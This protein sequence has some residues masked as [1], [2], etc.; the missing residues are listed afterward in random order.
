VNFDLKNDICTIFFETFSSLY[1][2]NNNGEN[3]NK[4]QL[5]NKRIRK[6]DVSKVVVQI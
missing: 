5:K 6:R 1:L 4:T 3:E 2:N